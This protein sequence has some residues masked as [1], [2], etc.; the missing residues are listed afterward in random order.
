MNGPL[1]DPPVTLAIAVDDRSLHGLRAQ[2]TQSA[3]LSKTTR[4]AFHSEKLG[5]NFQIRLSAPTLAA[6]V[7]WE[8]TKMFGGGWIATFFD[9]FP[10]SS[11]GVRLLLM[12]SRKQ[13]LR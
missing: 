3:C 10:S 5:V 2:R 7:C 12:K 9:R 11:F 13:V 6:Q 4:F 1:P 8:H